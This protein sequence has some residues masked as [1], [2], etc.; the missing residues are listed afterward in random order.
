MELDRVPTMRNLILVLG[1]Q[2][3]QTSAAFDGFDPENDV[4]WMAEVE[5][6]ATHVWCHKLRIAL[7]LSAMRHFRD[8]LTNSKRTVEYHKFHRLP[9]KDR[10]KSFNWWNLDFQIIRAV[11]TISKCL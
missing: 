1:D 10:G 8:E 3:D 5:E 4:V 11:L 9:S 7:F 6:E 2:L